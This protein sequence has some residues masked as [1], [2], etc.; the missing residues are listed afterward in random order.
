MPVMMVHKRWITETFRHPNLACEPHHFPDPWI[1]DGSQREMVNLGECDE[2][3]EILSTVTGVST[4]SWETKIE[5][6]SRHDFEKLVGLCS[7]LSKRTT[8]RRG[9]RNRQKIENCH[10]TTKTFILTKWG[11]K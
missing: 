7:A 9:E 11:K 1:V 2:I 3:L 6:D 8:K 5:K 4:V 10:T